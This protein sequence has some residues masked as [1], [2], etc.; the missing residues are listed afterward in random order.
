MFLKV[1]LKTCKKCY[2]VIAVIYISL[3]GLDVEGIMFAP[4]ASIG[5]EQQPPLIVFPHGKL[6]STLDLSERIAGQ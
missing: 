5:Q 1:Y 6:E 3:D 4:T 2:F